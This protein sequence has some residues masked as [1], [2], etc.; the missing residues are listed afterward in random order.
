MGDDLNKKL[1]EMTKEWLVECCADKLAIQYPISRPF[2][3]AITNEYLV[4]KF[5]IMIVGQEA[6]DY[7]RYSSDWPLED[8]QQ[9][10]IAY[11][12]RQL[13]Y[14]T[15]TRIN[16]SPFWKF[17]R[18]IKELGIEPSWNNVDKFH[19]IIEK[20]GKDETIPLTVEIE[21]KVDSSYGQ[22]NKSLLRREIELVT[23]NLVIFVIGPDYDKALAFSLGIASTDLSDYKPSVVCPCKE[24]PHSLIKMDC[25]VLWSYH[26]AYLNRIHSLD[27]VA[28]LVN[29]LISK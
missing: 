17:V 20:D 18:K 14:S 11:T 21:E 2:C 4:S 5:R 22:E 15:D 19:R 29:D 9:F 7:G 26:P 12:S 25:P 16:S 10:N 27:K 13:G 24:L 1:L 23:P 8:I 28:N 6:M 3:Y